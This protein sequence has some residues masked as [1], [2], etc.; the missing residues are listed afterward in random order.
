MSLRSKISGQK[1]Q[2]RDVCRQ[3]V[4]TTVLSPRYSPCDLRHFTGKNSTAIDMKEIQRAKS[5]IT[6]R[7]N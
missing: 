5:I 1:H 7:L 4:K 3:G 2:Q 6:P